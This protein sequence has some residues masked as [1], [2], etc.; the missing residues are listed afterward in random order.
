VSTITQLPSPSAAASVSLNGDTLHIESLSITHPE[1]AAL[2]REHAAAHGDEALAELVATALPVGIVALTLGGTSMTTASLQRT[3]AGI[4]EQVN[5]SATTALAEFGKAR[6]ALA[7]GE[8]DLVTRAQRVLDGLPQRVEMALSGEAANVRA[9]V[10]SAVAD[11]QA[12]GLRDLRA[13]MNQHSEV[14]RSALSLDN[15]DGPVQVLRQELTRQLESA[16]QDLGAQL[17]TVHGLLTAAQAASTAVASVKTTRASG[18]T[19]EHDAMCLA[20]EVVTAAGDLMDFT[21]SVPAPT[22]TSRA[23]DGVATIGSVVTGNGRNVRVVLEAKTRDRPLSSARWRD[24]LSASRDLREASGG[25][26]IVPANQIPGGD[27]RLFARVGERLFVV[28]ADR[29]ILTLV[30]LVM[31]ELCALATS[32]HA[33]TDKADLAKAEARIG[34]ALAALNDLDLVIRHSAAAAKALEKVQSV[35]IDVKARVAQTLL[36]SLAALHSA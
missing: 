15:N 13:L 2:A 23:G 1:A 17:T 5:A 32:Q 34:Q 22:S 8:Q 21:G 31:R 25:L 30:Y 3:F 16:R 10:T 4:S 33:D 11:V 18:I 28:V 29:Q 12:S 20:E 26:A 7:M 19:F 27:G 6:A 35:T 24:E 36:E 9:Q 14:V